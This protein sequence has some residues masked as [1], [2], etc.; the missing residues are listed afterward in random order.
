MGASRVTTSTIQVWDKYIQGAI[1]QGK[2]MGIKIVTE[3][4]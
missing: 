4:G 3:R 1:V 2:L